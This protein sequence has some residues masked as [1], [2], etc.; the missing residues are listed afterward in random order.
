[1]TELII[2]VV[3]VV[4]FLID[5]FGWALIIGGAIAG[6]KKY[7]WWAVPIG[8]AAAAMLSASLVSSRRADLGLDA[9]SG[10]K[11]FVQ[12]LALSMIG[13]AAYGLAFLAARKLAT[14]PN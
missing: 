6:Y 10:G 5:P 8:A 13:L 14:G 9:L 4:R 7:P 12:F 11:I 1:M 2:F 3:V